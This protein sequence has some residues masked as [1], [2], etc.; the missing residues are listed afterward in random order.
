MHFTN[1]DMTMVA[2]GVEARGIGEGGA[3]LRSGPAFVAVS[4]TMVEYVDVA[5]LRVRCIETSY[6]VLN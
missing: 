3:R 1:I 4:S 2:F 6:A 5:N